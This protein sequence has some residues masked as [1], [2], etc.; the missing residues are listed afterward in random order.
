MLVGLDLTIEDTAGAALRALPAYALIIG[1]AS[2]IRPD[3]GPIDRTKLVRAEQSLEL[4]GSVPLKDMA[5]VTARIE[6]MKDKS[7]CALVTT[8]TDANDTRTQR[9]LVLWLDEMVLYFIGLDAPEPLRGAPVAKLVA[10]TFPAP[11]AGGTQSRSRISRKP[12]TTKDIW[13]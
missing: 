6:L 2:N 5:G 9:D 4:A 10:T 1:Q 11:V 13:S 7:S 12:R 3:F 8:A